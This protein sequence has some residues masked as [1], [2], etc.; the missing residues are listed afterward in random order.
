MESFS[1][2]VWRL[3]GVFAL[4]WASVMLSI[5]RANPAA[6]MHWEQQKMGAIMIMRDGNPFKRR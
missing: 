3:M 5:S 6:E 4:I 1:D 2:A